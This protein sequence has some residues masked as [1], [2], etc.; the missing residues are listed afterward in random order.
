MT[1]RPLAES[2]TVSFEAGGR[3]IAS[4]SPSRS[5]ERWRIT[6]TAIRTTSESQTRF[7]EYRFS[8]SPSNLVEGT[9]TGN[10]NSSDS[11]VEVE[12]GES[13]VYVWEGG[14]PGASATVTVRGERML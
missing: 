3:A 1:T 4:L 8:E 12:P 9:E 13:L 6:L 10:L 2:V 7:S 11:V 14:T 5:Y